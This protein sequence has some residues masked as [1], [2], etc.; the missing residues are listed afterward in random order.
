M[1]QLFMQAFERGDWLAAQVQ[2]QVDSYSQTLAC[3]LLAAGHRPPE[4]LLPSATLPQ[5][6]NGKPIVLTGRHITTPAVNRTV[7][8]PL[9]V[10]STLSRNSEVP[11]GCAYPDTNCTVLDSS[12][13]E[14]EQQDQT[15]PNQD[16][17]ETCI[18]AKM[19]SRIQR[20]R[21][22]QRHIEDRLHG[23][24]QDA[25]SGSLDGMHKSDI[26]TLGSTRANASSSSIPCDDV[27]NNAETTSSAPGQGSG[28]CAIHGRSIDFLKCDDN[29]ENER[30]Q[31]DGFQPQIVE[32]KIISSD[33]DVGVN[34]KPSVRDPLSVPDLSM[35][36]VADSVCHRVPEIHML[37]EPKK[38]QFDGVE[39]VCMNDTSEQTG[40]QQE[41]GV[42]SDHLGRIPSSEN[43]SSTSS[44][45]PYSVGRLLLDHI[46]WG[47]LNPDGAPVEHH[48]KYALECGH[49]EPT[50][51]HSPNK[52]PSLT[53][54]AE[55]P[56][57]I[58]EPLLQKDTGH[59]PETNSLGRACP[60]VSRPLE[61][62]TSNS[63]ET[64][65]S[66]RPCSVV[67]P[68]LE[69]DTLQ[70]IEDTEKLQSSNSHFS[71]PYSGPLQLPTKLADSRFGAH[72]SSGTSPNS[73]LREEGHGQ[74]SNLRINDRNNQCSQGR[75]ALNL[76]LLPPQ[77]FSSNDVCQSSLLSYRMQSNDKHSTGCAAV[78]KFR[79]ADNELS[80]EPYLS[81]RS[82]LELNGTIPDAEIPL[83]HP[84]LDK[85]NEMLKANPVSDLVN[86]YSGRLDDDA[87]I[88]KSYG[89]SADNRNNESV[90]LKVMP[91][92]SS[93]RTSEMHGTERNSVV[94]SEKCIE[95]LRQGKEQETPHAEDNVQINANSCTAENVEKRK[96]ACTSESC[97]KSN[98]QQ[99][100]RGSAQKRS[101]ADGVQINEGT[102][103]KRKRIN[104]QDIA[105]P[106]S[107]NTKPLSLNHHD[108]V[109]THVVTAENFS[110]K[111]RPSGRYFLRSSGSGE[112][113]PLKSGTKNDTMSCK[114]SVASDVQQNRNSFPTLRNRSSLSELALCKSS[115]VKALSPHFGCGISSK[116]AV[117]EMDLQN[118]QAQLQNILDVA[119][120]PLPSSCNVAHDNMEL[121]IQE[122]NPYLR[123]EGLSVSTSSVEH[124]QLSLQMDEILSESVIV[125]PENYSSTDT[126]PSYGSEEHG[127]QASAP[128]VLA[129][130]KLSY[131]SGIEDRK[132][133]S[134][135]LTGRL[136]SD[137][138]IPRQ[139]DDESVD[140]NDTMPQ[141]ESFDFSVP[142]DSPTTEERT[143]EG[144]RDSRQFGPFSSDIS[145]KYKMNSLSG[146]RQLLATMSGKAANYSSDD[147]EKQSN[148][149]IDGRITDTYGPCGLGHNGS[150]FTSDVVALCS[151]NDSDK[152]ESSENPLTPAV[153]K[154]SL[155]KLSGKNGSV[156]EH[157][158]SIPELSC[159]RIDEDSDIAEENEYQDILPGSAGTQRQSGRKV[160]QDITGLCQNTGNSAAC[161]IGIMDTSDTDF[162]TESCSSELNH[163]PGLRN[164]GDNK[165]PKESYASLVKKGGKMSHSLRKRLSKTE[166]RH[167]SE[168]NTGKP[169]KPSN[170][171]ANVASFIPLVK[172][173]AQNAATCVKKD[174]RVKALEAAEAA[175]RLEEKKRNER[176]M[177]KAAAKL[178]REKLKQEKELKQKQEEEEK[179]KRDADVATRKRQRD[180]E[181]R[182]EKERKRKCV[183]EARKQQKQPMERRHA[184]SEKDAHPKAFSLQKNLAESVKGQVKPDEMTSLGGKATK[185]NNEKVVA[186][187]ERPAS[188][189]SQ[190]Q[191]SIPQS[192]EES[193]IM[194]PYKDSDDEDDDFEL[195]EESRRRRKLIPSWA[196]G[197]NLEKILLSNYALDHRKIFSQKCSS[198]LSEICPV[199]IPQRGFR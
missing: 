120:T 183:E 51:M 125:N 189:G 115:S 114:I 198:N 28:F 81:V 11:N 39:S 164:D 88:S 58:A 179:K 130:E 93:Q 178:E 78:N 146:M 144:L 71:P 136:L 77:N 69:N 199:H 31:S 36:S 141:F 191:E 135:D 26:G 86:C 21:S 186:A 143:F 7:F 161:S 33:S 154:Y 175:K 18:A 172:Q 127:K 108:V 22:R 37:I 193:Y 194:T 107:Y 167:M 177:R 160:L 19:F 142:F 188:F 181:E 168:T 103:S 53:C 6:L 129:H 101:V 176:E 47:H 95:S 190:S 8:L 102:S 119:T 59:I 174:V 75:S 79:S 196:R 165:K 113:M 67:N 149:S 4:W 163:H 100:D 184:N 92:N 104:C 27:A 80:Q 65:C 109:D 35:P 34:N 99:E 140:C 153:E 54:P 25:K 90:V 13:H 38:L 105:L 57:S 1:E 29:L 192:L 110:G 16:I 30:V 170:I 147:D 145:K 32:S 185:S 139:M 128:I 118:F 159:F 169:S 45:G 173:K 17:S 112:F 98:K 131:G 41:S 187:D 106:S 5:E 122:E 148:E 117:E 23:K 24:D 82:S 15:S 132:L 14:E 85:E 46:R 96:S 63:N 73:L 61:M 150:F 3:R 151:S 84:P 157:M 89:G 91:N 70:A 123:G 158:G 62:D 66:Q 152:Q 155:G 74:L 162:T 121:C 195:K 20:S 56:D 124:Q 94:L 50:D 137:S 72:A 180:E 166:A 87:Q 12:Q 64:N 134:E 97:E 49:P 55:A 138:S 44:Q 197:E 116:I 171:V 68:L 48:H 42:E 60:R 83:G 43:P 2:Q 111:S 156:S 9:A 133:R 40:Q 52:K 126:F 10:P 76:E 182:R